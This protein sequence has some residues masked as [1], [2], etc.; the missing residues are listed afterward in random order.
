MRIANIGGS[1]SIIKISY[2]HKLKQKNIDIDNYAIGASNSIIG[3]IQIIKNNIVNKYDLLIYEYFINDNNHFFQNINNVDRV[4]KTLI[5]ITNLCA[6]TNTKLLFIYIYNKKHYIQGKYKTSQ[7]CSLYKDFSNQNNISTIDVYDLLYSKYNNNWVNYYK[8][9]NTHLSKEGMNILCDEIISKIKKT[10]VPKFIGN[11]IGFNKLQL[12]QIDKHLDT[13]NFSNSMINVNYFTI[14]N[15]I[16]IKFNTNT[17][18]IAFEYIC[19]TESGYIEINNSKNI[20]QKNTLKAEKFVT[21]NKKSMVSI[22]T[23]NKKIL[24]DDDFVVIKNISYKKVN[25]SL[26]YDKERLTLEKENNNPT[27]FKLVS[28]LVTN[29]AKITNISI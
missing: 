24:E 25:K 17:T 27:N 29:N 13:I 14:S 7:M 23:F 12:I 15:E 21:I 9:D 1:N 5:E 2:T 26:Y 6:T 19:D 16:K 28:I 11:N 10:N 4:H 18:I 8:K 20:I 3:L 22:I